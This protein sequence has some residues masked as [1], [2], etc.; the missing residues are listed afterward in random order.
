MAKT[1]KKNSKATMATSKST[2]HAKKVL[3]SSVEDLGRRQELMGPYTGHERRDSKQKSFLTN[4]HD[5]KNSGSAFAAAS[6]LLKNVTI[7]EC[8]I[9]STSKVPG[10]DLVAVRGPKRYSFQA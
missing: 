2:I 3:F 8:R 6:S 1:R 4:F 9:G 7:I 5:Y 10:M